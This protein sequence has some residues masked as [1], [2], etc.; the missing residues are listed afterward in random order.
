MVEKEPSG[1]ASNNTLGHCQIK[2]KVSFSPWRDKTSQNMASINVP[3]QDG[4][5]SRDGHNTF[6]NILFPKAFPL[7]GYCKNNSVKLCDFLEQEVLSNTSQ[8]KVSSSGL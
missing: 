3:S 7:L 1:T 8:P 6:E 2:V 4:S 5:T